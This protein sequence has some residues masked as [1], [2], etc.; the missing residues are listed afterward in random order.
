[1]ATKL[2]A[3]NS[4]KNTRVNLLFSAEASLPRSLCP[5]MCMICKKKDLKVKHSR[6]LQSKIVTNT[7][8]KTL[9]EA[10]FTGND[11]E[12]IIVVSEAYLTANQFQTHK[13][14]YLDYTRMVIKSSSA[15][16]SKS[17]DTCL[18]N[19]DHDSVLSLIYND[20]FAGQ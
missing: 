11:K 6:Q 16:E 13:K 14:C 9:K 8:E 17:E 5:E 2:K 7:S 20:V 3:A 10:A 15:A 4:Q 12:M 1:M 18:G 19:R